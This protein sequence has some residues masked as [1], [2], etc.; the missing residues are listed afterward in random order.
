MDKRVSVIIPCFNGQEY[1]DVSIRSVFDQDWSNIELIII[2]DGSIDHSQEIIANW[3]KSFKDK[4]LIL[5]YVY[6][7]NQGPGAA[8][9]R[10][11][12][13]VTGEYLCLLDVDDYYLPNSIALKANYLD[14]HPECPI[15]RSNGYMEKGGKRWPFVFEDSEKNSKDVFYLLMKGKTN[16][17]AGSYML[18]TDKLFDFYPDKS[19]YPSRYGQNLQLLLPV[20]KDSPCGFIDQPLMVYRLDNNSLSREKDIAKNK[21]KRLK[22]IAGFHDIRLKMIARLFN[23]EKE[24]LYWNNVAEGIKYKSEFDVGIESEDNELIKASYD[25]LK[26]INQID[27]DTR[28]KYWNRKNKLVAITLKVVRRILRTRVE[29]VY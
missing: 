16:N 14:T 28:I 4:G 20:C 3:G 21:S 10:G 27:I 18:R 12:K 8:V 24:I 17:W 25:H 23:T 7:D 1:L 26:K 2:D 15:V 9:S 11:L 13:E 6:Q 22:N 19:I 29:R 5:K